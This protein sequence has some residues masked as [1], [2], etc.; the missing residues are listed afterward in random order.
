MFAA[1]H[2]TAAR[3]KRKAWGVLTMAGI[4]LTTEESAELAGLYKDRERFHSDG[5]EVMWACVTVPLLCLPLIAVLWGDVRSEWQ[6]LQAGE[7]RIGTS[8]VFMAPELFGFAGLIALAV[9]AAVYGIHTHGRH[10]VAIASFSVARVRG[11]VT[12]LIRYAEMESA[13]FSE[14]RHPRHRIITDELEVKARDGRT[15][16][17]YGFNAGQRKSM[18]EAAW[19]RA[20]AGER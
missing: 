12:K 5:R 4:Q 17:L 19:R 6:Q 7:L 8:L 18:I 1:L 2:D 9:S 16:L 15:I 11:G 20:T 14:R 10:G 13:T 3:S